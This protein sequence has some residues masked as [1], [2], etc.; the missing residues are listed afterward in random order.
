M[1]KNRVIAAI[2]QPNFLPWLGFFDKIVRSD[3]FVILDH[4]LNNPR[5]SIWTKRVQILCNQ[6]PFWLTVPLKRPKGDDFLL[7][8]NEMQINEAD[9]YRQKHLRTIELNYKK[10]PFYDEVSVLVASFYDYDSEFIAEKNT[11]FI[12]KVCESLEIKRDF[13]KSSE[14]GCQFSATEMLAELCQ[15]VKANTYIYGVGAS[16]Y[17]ENE[18]L[19]RHEIKAIAQNFVHPTY[20]QFNTT[21]FVK[22]LSIIDALMNCGIDGTKKLLNL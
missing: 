6:T 13:I 4:V 8:I 9:K 20:K 12:M 10:A 3:I 16:G 15:K 22:G 19:E 14:L 11:S 18:I 21:N 5:S 17:Q 7:P 2:H 1:Q